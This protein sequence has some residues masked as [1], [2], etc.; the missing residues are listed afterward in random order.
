MKKIKIT[1]TDTI[2]FILTYNKRLKK[3]TMTDSGCGPIVAGD[4]LAECM[5]NFANTSAFESTY[6][7]GGEE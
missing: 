1:K 7:K 4:T 3:W 6:K 5:L 2:E